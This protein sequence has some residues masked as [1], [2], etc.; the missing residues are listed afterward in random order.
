[1]IFLPY[2]LSGAL[3]IINKFCAVLFSKQESRE[4]LAVIR[5]K[6]MG[7]FPSV[8]S[9]ETLDFLRGRCWQGL[10]WRGR[11]SGKGGGDSPRKRPGYSSSRFYRGEKLQVSASLVVC[12]TESMINSCW[13]ARKRPGYSSSRFYRGEKLQ[14][15]ASL[16]VCRT[17]SMIN[18]C[19][20]ARLLAILTKVCL[21]G[22]LPKK[23]SL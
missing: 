22:V 16:V 6:V 13:E 14:V 18:S 20:E 3:W 2:V 17:E 21:I 8:G 12:R 7:R 15:S 5:I 11:F 1:M 19:W 9:W 10:G 4:P 23:L